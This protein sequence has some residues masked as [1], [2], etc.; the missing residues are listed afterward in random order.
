MCE[1]EAHD[2]SEMKIRTIMSSFNENKIAKDEEE[3][4]K[5]HEESSHASHT[6]EIF[7]LEA[8]KVL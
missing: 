1:F 8:I 7:D 4:T 2:A 6:R 3:C 5:A